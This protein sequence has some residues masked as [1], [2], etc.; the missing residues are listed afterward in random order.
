MTS[1]RAYCIV[2]IR[3]LDI[4]IANQ[5]HRLRREATG[6]AEFPLFTEPTAT[7]RKIIFKSFF[8]QSSANVLP[9]RQSL[10][11]WPHFDMAR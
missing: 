6:A 1:D 10:T 4:G 9:S 8:G 7:R 11:K 5:V 3:R 2:V